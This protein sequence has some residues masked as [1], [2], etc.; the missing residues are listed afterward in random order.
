MPKP[1]QPSK[2]ETADQ[3]LPSSNANAN[4][5]RIWPPRP[6]NDP[7]LAAD[8]LLHRWP[9]ENV[10]FR[11]SPSGQDGEMFV[12]RSDGKDGLVPTGQ[13]FYAVFQSLPADP[14]L[15]DGPRQN[16]YIPPWAHALPDTAS[17][18]NVMIRTWLTDH[19]HTDVHT[20]LSVA[21]TNA[22]FPLSHAQIQILASRV[23]TNNNYV[24]ARVNA[25]M[26]AASIGRS[27]ATVD[28]GV[29]QFPDPVIELACQ[30]LLRELDTQAKQL[31]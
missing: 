6:V 22:S 19:N 10:Y 18:I 21:S 14:T 11:L 25:G 29:K 15:P 5:P 4:T 17:T 2:V 12:P 3:I 7:Y 31:S 9:G 24:H 27:T 30:E 16:I 1:D 23:V 20:T 8:P 28:G 26:N 13:F